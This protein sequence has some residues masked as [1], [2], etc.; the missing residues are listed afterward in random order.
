MELPGELATNP[1]TRLRLRQRQNA[2]RKEAAR[3]S[4]VR[5]RPPAPYSSMTDTPSHPSLSFHGLKN[6]LDET[7]ECTPE[8]KRRRRQSRFADMV[9]KIG[10]FDTPDQTHRGHKFK[11]CMF[12]E[13]QDEEE[14]DS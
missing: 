13:E 6:P 2:E 12:D 3:L 1:E 7:A 11:R 4:G 5:E 8:P 10:V 14:D 9:P